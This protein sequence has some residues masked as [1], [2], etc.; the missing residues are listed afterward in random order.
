MR[1]RISII[2]LLVFLAIVVIACAPEEPELVATAEPADNPTT[3]PVTAATAEPIATTSA[4]DP[5]PTVVA[6]DTPATA[7]EP[8]AIATAPTPEPAATVAVPTPEPTAI[9]VFNVGDTVRLGD[10]HITVNSVRGSLGDSLWMPEAGNYFV[11]VD[12][13]FRNEGSEPKVVSTLLQMEIRDAEGR[14]YDIDFTAIAA[15][16]GA[17]PEGEIGP[18]GTLRGEVGF[19]IPTT[20]TG[21]TWRFSG[22]IFRLG[23][24]IFSLGAVTIPVPLGS[25][26]DNPIPA[27]EVLVGSDGTAIRVLGI[28]ENAREQIAAENQFNDPPAEGMR[29]FLISVEITYPSDASGSVKVAGYDFKLIGSNRVVYDSLQHSCSFSIP[30]ALG[31]LVGV[32]EIFPGGQTI[33]NICFQIPEGE[34]GLILI[35]EPGF[36]FGG[37]RRFLSLS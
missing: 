31:G 10:F 2:P 5:E 24:A 11:Y 19:Q 32:S 21:L 36:G 15:S 28:V 26:L 33:G 7:A 30:D 8:T 12:V 25:T 27:G 37:G 9:P 34:T 4:P 14:S 22:D 17:S 23:Q 13:T 6:T 29:F 3:A 20:A 16:G 35:H 18:G 1:H